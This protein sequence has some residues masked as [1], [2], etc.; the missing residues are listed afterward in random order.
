[1]IVYIIKLLHLLL[2]LYLFSSIFIKDKLTKLKA[3]GILFFLLFHYVTNYGKCGLT[4]LEYLIMGEKYQEGFLYRL[5]KPVIS[6]PEKYFEE[7]L[8]II[9]ISWLGILLYQIN[10][11]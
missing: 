8:F 5:I 10:T 4:E 11:E 3:A 9:H 1:M 7:Y 2:V 6:L